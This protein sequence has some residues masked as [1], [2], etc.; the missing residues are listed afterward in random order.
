LSLIRYI[1]F[2]GLGCFFG[3]ERPNFPNKLYVQLGDPRNW[4]VRF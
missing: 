1:D 3:D 2:S 4:G